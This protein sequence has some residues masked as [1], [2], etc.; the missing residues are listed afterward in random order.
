MYSNRELPNRNQ[1]LGECFFFFLSRLS[2]KTHTQAILCFF[3]FFAVVVV[4]VLEDKEFFT[5]FFVYVFTFFFFLC[6]F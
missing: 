5:G 2:A 1:N 3:F 4:V 6:R